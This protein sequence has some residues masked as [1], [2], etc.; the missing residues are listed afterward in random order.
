MVHGL[1]VKN[2]IEMIWYM[3]FVRMYPHRALASALANTPCHLEPAV[4]AINC[5]RSRQ[6]SPHKT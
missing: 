2:M 5:H 6:K 1:D 4:R 3:E